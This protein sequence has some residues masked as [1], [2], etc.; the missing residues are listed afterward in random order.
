MVSF[1]SSGV[2]VKVAPFQIRSSSNSQ[3]RT[4]SSVHVLVG[5]VYVWERFWILKQLGP[6]DK[7]MGGTLRFWDLWPT[8]T[9]Y[10]FSFTESVKAVARSWV[11]TVMHLNVWDLFR[12][13]IVLAHLP[14]SWE[15]STAIAYIR[16]IWIRNQYQ[17]YLDK[18]PWYS[19]V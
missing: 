5:S 12:L 3:N 14:C 8:Y 9:V 6:K 18:E 17:V 19:K 15:V 7:V 13:H 2:S 10:Q 4:A 16:Y 11:S 1:K